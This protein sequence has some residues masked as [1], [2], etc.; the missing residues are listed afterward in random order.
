MSDAI[1]ATP[2]RINGYYDK[3][4]WDSIASRDMRLQRC[5]HCGHVRY[6][7]AAICPQCLSD[8]AEWAPVSGRGE[9]LSWAV[10]HRGY[11]PAY[12]PPYN[13]IA[14]RLE[15]GPIMI[16][17]LEGDVPEGT[18]I[19]RPVQMRYATMPDGVVLPRFALRSSGD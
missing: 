2:K 19:G 17:N 4:M 8:E 18:W 10:F 3:P 15:E 14:V 16:G 6:P 7:P 11:L 12:P 5:G 1:P 9:I 13:V